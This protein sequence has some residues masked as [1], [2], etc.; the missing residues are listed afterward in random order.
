MG[1]IN[2]LTSL[3]ELIWT[4]CSKV[5][6]KAHAIGIDKYDLAKAM[7]FGA[8]AI[9]VNGLLWMGIKQYED[10]NYGSMALSSGYGGVAI[11]RYYLQK[12]AIDIEK[13]REL[14]TLLQGATQAPYFDAT[15]PLYFGAGF[16]FYFT[17]IF[18]LS[19]YEKAINIALGSTLIFLNLTDYFLTQIPR[20][21]AAK[22]S[23]FRLPQLV[24][25]RKPVLESLE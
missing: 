6:D 22:K 3:D 11:F 17:Q 20:P 8:H 25:S 1:I 9:L 18:E 12:K 14:S 19:T 5:V 10:G 15:R 16:S 24:L 7:N 2:A 21:P 13:E 23:I 4:G